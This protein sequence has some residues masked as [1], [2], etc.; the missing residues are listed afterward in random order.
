MPHPSC[1]SYPRH[2]YYR[3]YYHNH[4]HRYRM[5]YE[6]KKYRQE[7]FAK[8]YEPYGGE[9]AYH[10]NSLMKWLQEMKQ[11]EEAKKEN[12]SNIQSNC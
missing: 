5:N 11:Q 10:K 12:N 2:E 7:T 9:V 6:E 3:R 8:I 1:V 4:K